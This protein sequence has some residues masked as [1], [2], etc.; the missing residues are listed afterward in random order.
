MFYI[1]R[2]TGEWLK[3]QGVYDISRVFLFQPFPRPLADMPAKLK[4][5]PPFRKTRRGGFFTLPGHRS[6][7]FCF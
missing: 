4:F 6:G 2:G 5:E 7:R 3:R 1:S